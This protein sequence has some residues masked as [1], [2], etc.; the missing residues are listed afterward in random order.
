MSGCECERCNQPSIAQAL[1]LL[2]APEIT[3]KIAHRHGRARA[4]ADSD[5]TPEEIVRELYLA[6]LSRLPTAAEASL[7]RQAFD[8][9]G[10]DRRA[11]T[12]DV[13]WAILNSREFV[14]N[15]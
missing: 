11:A 9:P 2:N 7:M 5:H 12:Q 15:H 3:E 6:T 4:L 13:L 14:F 8:T 1:H 10:L